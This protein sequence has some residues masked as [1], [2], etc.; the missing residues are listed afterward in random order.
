MQ[1]LIIFIAQAVIDFWKQGVKK[2]AKRC[3]FYYLSLFYDFKCL[4][5]W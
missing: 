2:N 5:F 4:K 1:Y 3:M